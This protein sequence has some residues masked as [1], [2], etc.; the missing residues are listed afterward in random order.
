M[1]KILTLI[2]PCYNPSESWE[3]NLLKS[4]QLF[5]TSIGQECRI[6]LVNDGCS[7]DISSEV[8][9]LKSHIGDNISYIAHQQNRG[10]GAALKTGVLHAESDLYMFT[11]VDFPYTLESMRQVFVSA[12]ES[13]G[14]SCGYRQQTYYKQLSSTRAFISKS[15]RWL[16]STVLALPTNDTQ[17]GLKAFDNSVKPLFLQC[18]TDRFLLDL[19]LLLAVNAHKL[20]IHPVFV[21]LNEGVTFTKFHL[22]VLFKE[23]GNFLN[24]V[25][26]YRILHRK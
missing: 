11:D 19:E 8:A 26:H 14:I 4:Y 25:I 1:S 6:V 7:S 2:V 17:C 10:K 9:F 23:L 13:P 21:Q 24:L 16:N 3:I 15:L 22:S 20:G 18:K 12:C 5:C